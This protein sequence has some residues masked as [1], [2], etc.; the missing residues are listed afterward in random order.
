VTFWTIAGFDDVR[1]MMICSHG[2]V[3]TF[4]ADANDS[5]ITSSVHLFIMM[6]LGLHAY[7]LDWRPALY[8]R[9][10]LVRTAKVSHPQTAKIAV[11]DNSQASLVISFAGVRSFEID[12]TS[13]Y[14]E[15]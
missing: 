8:L 4:A 1:A 2:L 6:G 10:D 13:G 15:K 5:K 12:R 7:G 11:D 14:G 3:D 9:D